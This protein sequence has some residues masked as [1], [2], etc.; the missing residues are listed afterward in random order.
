MFQ[1]IKNLF[2]TYKF[3]NQI[4]GKDWTDKW[5]AGLESNL[6]QLAMGGKSVIQP[7]KDSSIIYTCLKIISERFASVPF[8]ITKAGKIV[9]EDNDRAVSL[10]DNPNSGQTSYEFW[11][12][13][14]LLFT[15]RGEVFIYIVPSLGQAA[16]TST[17]PAELLILD[18]KYM[19]EVLNVNGIL[20]GWRY[21]RYDSDVF[22]AEH[23]FKYN[24]PIEIDEVIQ[25][26]NVN[27]VNPYR[28]MSPIL[29][30]QMALDSDRFA[31]EYNKNFFKNSAMPSGIITLGE[32]DDSTLSDMGKLKK[33]WES[34]HGGSAKAHK[35]AV[36][37]FGMKYEP[38]A[39][40]QQ[41]MDFIQGRRYSL[42]QIASAMGVPEPLL[43]GESKGIY[44][45]YVPA[46]R[47]LYTRT[48]LPLATRIQHKLNVEFFKKFAVGYE[49]KFNFDNVVELQDDYTKRTEQSTKLQY[50][51]Y[52][53]NEIN[54]V[55]NLG[56]DESTDGDTRYIPM[57]LLPE[58]LAGESTPSFDDSK[59]I[60]VTPTIK[61]I[62]LK[63]NKSARKDR[64]LQIFHRKHAS[65]EKLFYKK[66]KSYF[67]KQ[68]KEVL[69]RLAE[70]GKNKL[71]AYLM[72]NAINIVDE[73]SKKLIQTVVPLYSETV[74]QG[75]QFALDLL[76]IDRDYILN[77][78]I[79]QTRANRITGIVDTTFNQIKNQINEGMNAGETIGDITQRIKNVFN[80]T[81][82]RSR[83]IARTEVTTMMNQAAVEEYKNNGVKLVDWITA[84]DEAV[85]E[86][87][88]ENGNAD[89]RAPGKEWPSGETSP[90]APNCRCTLSPIVG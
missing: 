69:R 53:R 26:K 17:L 67:Y 43:N 85:R 38:I 14:S 32:D 20:T 21:N 78:Q 72:F 77:N 33:M 71:E 57:N 39:L 73:E 82:T 9:N 55:L 31:E 30:I 29:S 68:R 60:D 86:E 12:K 50:L 70:I 46:F 24:V 63:D 5:K 3:I 41:E 80:T 58:D 2:T 56:F 87:H 89:P 83:L 59:M 4:Q 37:R 44:D 28:G 62:E 23:N 16:G 84:G 48:I 42:G 90:S 65:L 49:C 7:Q 8:Q 74:K 81:A 51:G 22:L 66:I 35:T 19:E 13:L 18:G 45:T 61:Q 27:S 34:D 25:I 79:I 10:F 1:T 40:T 11:E 64:I 36:L 6:L 75:G 15:L 52:T 54:D 47:D 88:V 76:N